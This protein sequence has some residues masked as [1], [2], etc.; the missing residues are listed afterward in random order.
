MFLTIILRTFDI[1]S[2]RLQLGQIMLK[3]FRYN[4][5]FGEKGRNEKEN[6]IIMRSFNGIVTLWTDNIANKKQN[7][8]SS[9]QYQKWDGWTAK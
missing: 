8:G 4:E 7:N 6:C 9:Q 1:Y 3:M 2:G 5:T